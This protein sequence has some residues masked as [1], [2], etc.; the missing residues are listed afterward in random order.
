MVFL[1]SRKIQFVLLLCWLCGMLFIVVE[2]TGE[3]PEWLA[4]ATEQEPAQDKKARIGDVPEPLAQTPEPPQI[5]EPVPPK[6]EKS[7]LPEPHPELN[8]C[9]ALRQVAVEGDAKNVLVLEMDY[10]AAQNK[11][12]RIEKAHTY[13]LDDSPVFVIAFGA[14]WTSDIGNTQL[15]VGMRTVS[16]VNLILSKSHTLRLLIQTQS[17]QDS[18]RARARITP[19]DTGLRAEIHFSE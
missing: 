7:P 6:P 1:Y 18:R 11:G 2:S 17:M 12:F 15:Q 9:L 3:M 4:E 8:R 10:V 19:T 5:I 16:H 14:P 13:Y